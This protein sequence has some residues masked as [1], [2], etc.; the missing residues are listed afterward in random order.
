[1]NT[2]EVDHPEVAVGSEEPRTG[3]RE[4][5]RRRPFLMVA[6][7]ATLAAATY[8]IGVASDRY[9]SEAHVVVQRTDLPS[10]QGIELGGVLA[11]VLGGQSQ[12]DQYLLRSHLLS[13]D[14]LGRL[15]ASL[16]LRAHYSDTARDPLSRLWR[17]EQEWFFRHYRSRVDAYLDDKSGVLSI[18]AQAYDPKMAQSIVL[19]LVAEGER[20]M[21]RLAH[22]LAEEQVR[23]LE[24]QVEQMKG[25]ALAAREA[26]VAYQNRHGLV[27]P[28]AAVESLS[29]TLGQLEGRRIELDAQRSALRSYLVPEHPSIVQLD[30]QIAAINRQIRTERAR[31]ASPKGGALNRTVEESQRL[32]FEAGFAQEV[33]QSALTALERGRVEAARTIKKVAV[34][35][36]PTLPEYAEQPRRWYNTLAFAL[37]AFLLAGVAH[38][39]AAIVREHRD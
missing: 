21:N 6:S 7:M 13:T 17:S 30:Q 10:G 38:L 5:W 28:Q 3:V 2:P 18:T 8:W 25:K 29:Q 1:M 33:Y 14:M 15:D 31:L 24:T 37:A 23:F 12:N 32:E 27:S 36:T 19:A 39:L 34:V 11:G 35:Q 20:F 22:T 4:H 9:V 16:Q 26:V